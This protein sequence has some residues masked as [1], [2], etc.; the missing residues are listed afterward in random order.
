V[1]DCF[2]KKNIDKWRQYQ[3]EKTADPDEMASR[4]TEL[5]NDLGYAKTFFRTVR[6]PLT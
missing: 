5:V 1:K 3:Y 4:F 6:L 2:I